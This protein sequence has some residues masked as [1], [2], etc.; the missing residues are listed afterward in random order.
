[1]PPPPDTNDRH[2]H[3][4]TRFIRVLLMHRSDRGVGITGI[5]LLVTH[6]A[7]GFIYPAHIATVL[8]QTLDADDDIETLYS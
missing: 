4:G 5:A 1:M 6:D 7:I 2:E 3:E 8:S